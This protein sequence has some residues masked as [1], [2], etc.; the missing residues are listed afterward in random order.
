MV[1]GGIIRAAGAI[2]DRQAT[3][4]EAAGY[5]YPAW[6]V[7]L[8][9]VIVFG[10]AIAAAAQR[11]A[12]IP[13]QWPLLAALFT[14][15]PMVLIAVVTPNARLIGVVL[16]IAAVEPLLLLRPVFPDA[17]PGCLAI[18]TTMMAMAASLR[19]SLLTLAASALALGIPAAL[20]RLDAAPIYLV[21]LGGGWVL[22]HMLQT[23][24]RL[25]QTQK[26]LLRSEREAQQLL[27]DRAVPEERRRITRE[28]HDIAGHSLSV[29]LLH[30]TGARHTLAQ[31]R[32]IDEA[33]E[34]LDDAERIGRQAM[35]D[36]R[37]TI[38]LLGSDAPTPAPKPGPA[39]ID[40]MISDFVAAGLRVK[41]ETSGPLDSV[42]EAVALTLFR[43]TQES[44][45]NV[46]K[47][48]P[49]STVT[50]S[51]RISESRATLSIHNTG[52]FTPTPDASGNG[53]RG[54]RQR[55]EALGDGRLDTGPCA[56]GWRVRA[57]LP[58][59]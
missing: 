54:M 17:A 7:P 19:K 16:V 53:L 10:A 43:L 1:W 55:V 18:L 14:V 58:F 45:T 46:A 6:Y 31:D 28:V 44:L 21:L 8:A 2:T 33:M 23:H 42:S 20:G 32:D 15:T 5:D 41:Y 51:L 22:G 39:D 25:L 9:D 11:G 12:L 30:L 13:P 35:A 47:H 52:S 3:H 34:A 56:D 24:M 49:A 59:Q 27:A 40:D 29:T 57:E 38:G 50:A 37:R 26:R 4:V 36:I 48:A